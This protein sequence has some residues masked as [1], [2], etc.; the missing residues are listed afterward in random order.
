MGD[1]EDKKALKVVDAAPAEE[2]QKSFSRLNSIGERVTEVT[3]KTKSLISKKTAA[4]EATKTTKKTLDGI[5]IDSRLTTDEGLTFRA[6]MIG[7]LVVK[8]HHGDDMAVRAIQDLK[9]AAKN[10]GRH[11]PR[12]VIKISINGIEIY[13]DK[14]MKLIM[15]HELEKISYLTQDPIDNKVFAYIHNKFRPTS[16]KLWSLKSPKCELI[17]SHMK[18]VFHYMHDQRRRGGSKEVSS[19]LKAPKVSVEMPSVAEASAPIEGED[20]EDPLAS[21]FN[22]GKLLDFD[23]L[24]N[25]TAKPVLIGSVPLNQAPDNL[26]SN[27]PRQNST[28]NRLSIGAFSEEEEYG[29]ELYSTVNKLRGDAKE[30]ISSGNPFIQQGASNSSEKPPPRLTSPDTPPPTSALGIVNPAWASA[31]NSENNSVA[32]DDIFSVDRYKQADSSSDEEEEPIYNAP[33]TAPAKIPSS[34][35]VDSEEYEWDIGEMRSKKYSEGHIALT[36]T[37]ERLSTITKNAVDTLEKAKTENVNTASSLIDFM[38]FDEMEQKP[39]SNP[40]D[41]FDTLASRQAE[42]RASA[43]D[44]LLSLDFSSVS[45]N[46]VQSTPDIL[47]QAPAQQQANY[48]LNS[49]INNPASYN[50]SFG[51]SQQQSQSN[52][53]IYNGFSYSSSPSTV[54]SPNYAAQSANYVNYSAMQGSQGLSKQGSPG[55]SQQP[56]FSFPVQ[57]SPPSSL[58]SAESA[59]PKPVQQPQSKSTIDDFDP[60][61]D[62]MGAI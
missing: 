48:D 20:E 36:E 62:L 44:D 2:E 4:K 30:D 22:Y 61:A 3:A 10:S 14:T 57:F 15:T 18:T 38:A 46:K 31:A 39:Q 16:H 49:L 34:V 54:Q 58:T 41:L 25:E 35:F 27:M 7:S 24:E 8:F 43:Q 11:K 60:F 28:G 42:N 9:I 23:D 1:A 13:E 17:V 56:N 26:Y 55:F 29:E 50:A 53:G 37:R 40:V 52:T 19:P 33:P 6:K 32:D 51:Q 47:V 12:I 59:A 21:G 5:L 45:V